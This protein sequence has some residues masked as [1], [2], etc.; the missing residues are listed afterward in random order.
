[1]SAV[2]TEVVRKSAAARLAGSSPAR[3]TSIFLFIFT[4][5]C[6]SFG[7]TVWAE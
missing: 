5:I 3:G 6:G 7:V 2:K 4:S 1:M